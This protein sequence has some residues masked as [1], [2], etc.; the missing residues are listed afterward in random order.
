MIPIKQR[1]CDLPLER[2][3]TGLELIGH[4]LLVNRLKKPRT[5]GIMNRERGID[6]LAGETIVLRRGFRHLGDLA[7]NWNGTIGADISR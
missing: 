2:D 6:D 5:E 7:L 3:A 4:A 1:Q